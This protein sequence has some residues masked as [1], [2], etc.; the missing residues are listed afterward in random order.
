MSKRRPVTAS[1]LPPTEEEGRV[2]RER[3][4]DWLITLARRE[5]EHGAVEATPKQAKVR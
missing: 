5:E 1:W 4:I 3:V 2:I